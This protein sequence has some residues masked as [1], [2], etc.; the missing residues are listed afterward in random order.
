MDWRDSSSA[1]LGSA[2]GSSELGNATG[3]KWDFGLA[4]PGRNFVAL[5]LDCSDRAGSYLHF[6]GV[7]DAPNDGAL[8]PPSLLAV[9]SGQGGFFLYEADWGE[10]KH[11]AKVVVRAAVIIDGRVAGLSNAVTIEVD[12]NR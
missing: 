2:C 8:L 7:P 9:R 4:P 11:A 5:F 6:P 1:L 10:T 12:A 3:K